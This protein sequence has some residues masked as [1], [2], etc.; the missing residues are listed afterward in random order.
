MPIC[1]DLGTNNEKFLADPLYLGRQEKRVPDHEVGHWF[2][3][4]RAKCALISP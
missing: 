4:C 1:L 3:G 2:E